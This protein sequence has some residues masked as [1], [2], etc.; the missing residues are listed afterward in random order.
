MIELLGKYGLVPVVVLDRADD[1]LP[2]GEALDLGGLPI[3]EITLRTEA[4]LE[5]IRRIRQAK[6]E[7]LLGAG[8]VLTLDQCKA[9]VEAGASYIVSPGFNKEIVEW[10][11]EN[12]VDVLPG[13][14][15]PTEITTALSYG[16]KVLKF[17]P[18]NVYGGITG[19][20]ALYAAFQQTGLKFV[21]TGGV[22]LSNL[23]D[24]ADKAFVHAVGGSWLTPKD[25][26]NAGDFAEITRITKDSIAKLLG[27]DPRDPGEEGAEGT[28]NSID[29]AVFYLGKNDFKIGEGTYRFKKGRLVSARL[30]RKSDGFG[31]NLKQK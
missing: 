28:V 13:C 19:I 3:M 6:P 20:K 21:P 31:V 27:I 30:R 2:L 8:T 12:K 1:A 7:Y 17:F 15:T 9:S 25:L 14:V 23:Q 18:A 5:S 22:S 16:L 11:L 10:C 29:R 4:G 26:V 24:F